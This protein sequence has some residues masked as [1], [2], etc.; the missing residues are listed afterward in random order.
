M[1]S[2]LQREFFTK[3]HQVLFSL[4]AKTTLG[5]WSLLQRFTNLFLVCVI[6]R[7]RGMV[8]LSFGF[9]HS[10]QVFIYLFISLIYFL[11]FFS[12]NF[13]IS[14]LYFFLLVCNLI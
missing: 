4:L 5:F 14:F 12:S 10:R 3:F 2:K 6:D 1:Y 8:K 11:D 7:L 13:I 9:L